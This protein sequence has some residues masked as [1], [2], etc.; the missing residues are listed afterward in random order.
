MAFYDKTTAGGRRKKTHLSGRSRMTKP[1]LPS[2]NR[3]GGFSEMPANGA[4]LLLFERP[5]LR[6]PPDVETIMRGLV[7]QGL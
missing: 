2:K 1:D 6:M 5:Q 3:I 7:F 4:K